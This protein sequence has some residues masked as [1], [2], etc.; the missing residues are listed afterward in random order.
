[1]DKNVGPEMFSCI[2]RGCCVDRK[3]DILG[4]LKGHQ[5]E[6][7]LHQLDYLFQPNSKGH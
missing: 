1:M 2:K 4:F 5:D 3:T 7:M 6:G